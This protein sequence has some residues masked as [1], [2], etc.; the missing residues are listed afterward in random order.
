[1]T[2][3]ILLSEKWIFLFFL[4]WG[5]GGM[6][7]YS[8]SGAL[9]ACAIWNETKTQFAVFSLL[10]WQWGCCDS[11]GFKTALYCN[12]HLGVGSN[13]WRFIN[14]VLEKVYHRKCF[15]P[16]N[17]FSWLW[18][19]GLWDYKSG[20]LIPSSLSEINDSFCRARLIPFSFSSSFF[21]FHFHWKPCFRL[22]QLHTCHFFLLIPPLSR[23]AHLKNISIKVMYHLGNARS[24]KFKT[25]E[26]LGKC[27]D[28]NI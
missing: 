3:E 14:M 9:S 5:N 2:V 15:V 23:N 1:M 7:L 21:F 4:K 27:I 24:K 6:F 13:F 8:F 18:F 26:F 17:S 10:V 28:F 11:G 12:I 19:I 16:Y 25:F 22:P 20:F